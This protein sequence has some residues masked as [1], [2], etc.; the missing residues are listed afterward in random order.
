MK[1]KF[2]I[3]IFIAITGLTACQVV[4]LNGTSYSPSG[5]YASGDLREVKKL[6]YRDDTM[7]PYYRFFQP[8]PQS[9]AIIVG[10][11]YQA[12]VN[13]CTFMQRYRIRT[14]A[15]FQASLNLFKYRAYEMGAGRVV[16][17]K[18][19]EI[20]A[21]ESKV[22]VDDTFFVGTVGTAL[23]NAEYFTILIGDLYDCPNRNKL[24]NSN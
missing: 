20:D 18:H 22:F 5:N 3:V 1:L 6:S 10:S 4:P 19:E 13:S 12:D 7:S 15:D 2:L 24:I 21:E 8:T 11:A 9:R 14:N 23:K 17:V 16:V